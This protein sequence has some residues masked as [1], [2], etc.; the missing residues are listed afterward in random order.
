MWKKINITFL[1]NKKLLLSDYDVF[2]NH[3][4]E[5][6]WIKLEQFSVGAYT[7]I[8]LKFVNVKTKNTFFM[9]FNNTSIVCKK[10]EIDI[11]TFSKQKFYKVS[12]KKQDFTKDYSDVKDKINYLTNYR[13]LG[14]SIDQI[15]E[16]ETLKSLKYQYDLMKLLNLRERENY[17]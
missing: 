3:N 12:K 9:F 7:E 5:K 2:I 16:L 17:E 6:N 13:F 1:D 11:K 15:I 10:D 8:L 14:L 4:E